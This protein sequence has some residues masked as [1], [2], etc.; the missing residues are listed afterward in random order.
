MENI[1]IS[2]IIPSYNSQDTIELCLGA[3]MGQKF[4][5]NFETIIVDCSSDDSVDNIIAK[6]PQIIFDKQARRLNP[7]T[8]RNIGVRRARGE[9]LLFL[10]SDV[11]LEP[12]ALQKIWHYY[13]NGYRVFSGALELRLYP[14]FS[15]PALIKH[16]FF[17]HE[18]QKGMELAKRV[19]LCSA[20]LVFERGL[21]LLSGDFNDMEQ[22][23]DTE[24]T[25]R[26]KKNNKDIELFF[27]PEVRGSIIHTDSL[28][29]VF[30]KIYSFG[31][32]FYNIRYKEKLR[33]E[34][35]L[36][37]ALFFPFLAFAKVTRINLRNILHKGIKG[38]IT[39]LLI[40]PLMYCCGFYWM[41]GIYK[42]MFINTQT[43]LKK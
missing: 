14:H 26:F 12:D 1:N 2:V 33:W 22:A 16:Y 11:I 39:G 37:F 25:E 15:W 34:G 8:A 32:N 17:F 30:R 19:N 38:A 23:E 10:D 29:K 35:K 4:N 36:F 7:G 31:Y 6:Y 41:F 27:V 13:K 24:L 3:L 43:T 21:F 28:Q 9:V 18:Y 40:S 5:L 20:L 42:S